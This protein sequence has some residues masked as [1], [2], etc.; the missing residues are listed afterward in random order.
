MSKG[1]IASLSRNQKAMSARTET[2]HVA[3]TNV[4]ILFNSVLKLAAA[5]SNG[6]RRVLVTQSL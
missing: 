3:I 2:E 4:R 5:Q 1:G 6:R